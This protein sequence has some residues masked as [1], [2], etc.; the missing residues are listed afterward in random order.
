ET[1]SRGRAAVASGP[2]ARG[3]AA[4]EQGQAGQEGCAQRDGRRGLASASDSATAAIVARR[5]RAVAR[6]GAVVASGA[7]RGRSTGA[8]SPRGGRDVGIGLALAR[9]ADAALAAGAIEL[10]RLDAASLLAD[11]H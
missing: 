4:P 10:V 9:D 8:A 5:A 11:A 2:C 1:L 7:T 3:R 6:A